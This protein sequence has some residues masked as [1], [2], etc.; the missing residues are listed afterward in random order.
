MSSAACSRQNAA[1]R[2]IIQGHNH[3]DACCMMM[4]DSMLL[5][6]VSNAQDYDVQHDVFEHPQDAL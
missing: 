6:G 4:R 2:A 3:D 1:V 5:Q